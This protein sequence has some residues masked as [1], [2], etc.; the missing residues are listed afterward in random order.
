VG[1]SA[2]AVF[3]VVKAQYAVAGLQ[4]ADV[5]F[6]SKPTPSINSAT[7][8]AEAVSY[9]YSS[10]GLTFGAWNENNPAGTYIL[11]AAI[12]ETETSEA[13]ESET[14]FTVKKETLDGEVTV[15]GNPQ[16]DRTK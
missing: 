13:I 1:A 8:G 10:D 5:T 16:Y 14:T 15:K 2:V 3:Y 12:P 11:K 7:A 4:C 9:T 6:G